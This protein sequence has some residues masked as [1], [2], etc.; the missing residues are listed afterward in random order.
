MNSIIFILVFFGAFGTSTLIGERFQNS[1]IQPEIIVTDE[2]KVEEDTNTA[3]INEKSGIDKNSITSSVGVAEI[4]YTKKYLDSNVKGAINVDSGSNSARF[5]VIKSELRIWENYPLVGV[6]VAHRQCYIADFLS[7]Q[8]KEIGEIANCIQ[9]QQKLGILKS[10]FPSPCEYSADL[11]ELGI[12]GTMLK[13]LPFILLFVILGKYHNSIRKSSD[14]LLFIMVIVAMAGCLANGFSNH[15]TVI[16][17]TWILLGIIFAML[18]A[19]WEK[20]HEI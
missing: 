4:E 10:G 3:I 11:A 12:V 7:S 9:Y 2:K 13:L 5:A 19:V 15:L 17:T 6:G 16:Y 14:N 8:E 1:S 18:C 20:K